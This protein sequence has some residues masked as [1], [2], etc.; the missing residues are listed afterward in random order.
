VA[1]EATLVRRCLRLRHQ[2]ATAVGPLWQGHLYNR[3]V[4]LLRG[5][6]GP[7]RATQAATWLVQHYALQAVL[8]IGFAGG[9]Q[10]SVATGDAVLP[11]RILTT[12]VGA[13][14]ISPPAPVG[15]VPDAGLAHHAA[16][17]ARQAG[18]TLHQG[19]LLSVIEMVAHAVAK[20]RLGE[21][22]GALAVDMESYSIGRVAVAHHL[23]FMVLRTIFDTQT[24]NVPFQASQFTSANGA[25][26]PLRVLSYIVRH[27]HVL[28]EVPHAWGKVRTAGRGL[29]SWLGH[30]LRQLGQLGAVH[31]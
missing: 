1:S 22:F 24:D 30:F 14:T 2:V 9:L 20:Q 17:A 6:M 26:Q 25:L 28:A 12:Q 15:I 10:A 31:G 8:S 5:G 29:E 11:L 13:E 27:P 3:E 19:T 23:P 4:V 21:Q 7:E 18:L 16:I